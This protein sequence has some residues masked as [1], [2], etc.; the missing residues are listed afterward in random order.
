MYYNKTYKSGGIMNIITIKDLIFKYGEKIVFDRLNLTINSGE[1]V[2]LVGTNG[3]G[4]STLVKILTGLYKV[5]TYINI[6]GLE[7]N[8]NNL[9][10]IRK[11]IGVIFENVDNQFVA[12]TVRDD[13]AFTLENLNYS[14]D[15][16]HKT[17]DEISTYLGIND[18]LEVEPHLLSGALKIK[19][20][21]ASSL[22]LEPKIL[23]LDES[24]VA[25]DPIEREEILKILKNLQKDKNLTIIN[26]THD[27]EES[28]YGNRIIVIGNGNIILNGPTKEILQKEKELKKEGF[29]LPFMVDLS[30]KLKYYGLLDDII[31]D[32]DEMVGVLWK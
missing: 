26:I 9:I 28:L 30:I 14:K 23:I 16:I 27:L 2:T 32:M 1:W 10:E 22:V 18:I 7:L 25:L 5:N 3:S 31:F 21:L 8:K 24:L 20:A 12:E 13:I 19:V 6:D 11:K 17:I 15:K 4:K 29:N